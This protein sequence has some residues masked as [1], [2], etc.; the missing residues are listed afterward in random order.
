MRP[1]IN[2]TIWKFNELSG[3]LK[4]LL[5]YY[6]YLA[7]KATLHPRAPLV[8][9]NEL[10]LLRWYAKIFQKKDRCTPQN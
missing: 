4:T 2:C 9:Q 1:T 8:L 10:I 5:R 6:I 3:K 7:E